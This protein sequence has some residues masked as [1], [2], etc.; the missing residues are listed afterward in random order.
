MFQIT[1]VQ[2]EV[3]MMKLIF[4][5]P[6]PCIHSF[7]KNIVPNDYIYSYTVKHYL[8]AWPYFRKPIAHDLFRDF[9]IATHRIFFYNLYIRNYWRGL[10]FHVS[11]L[12]RIYAKT[13]SSW[14]KSFLQY[15]SFFYKC[16]YLSMDS[17]VV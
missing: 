15:T 10:Y 12:L 7:I 4:S 5:S 11:M 9:I 6:L 1:S 14:I 3:Q 8:F 17:S 2:I 16:S 13:K